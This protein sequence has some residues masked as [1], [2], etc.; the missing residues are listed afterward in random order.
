MSVTDKG[1]VQLFRE[2]NIPHLLDTQGYVLLTADEIK[3]ISGREPRLMV[4]F[5]TREYRPDT[6]KKADCTI[7]PVRNG[8]YVIVRGDGYVRLP[9]VLTVRT[10]DSDPFERLQTLPRLCKSESQ[11]IDV[12][13]ASGMLERFV[14]EAG[15][16]LTIRGR[17]R[18]CPFG[19]TFHGASALKFQVNGVQV[20]VDAGYEGDR[21][22]LVEAKMGARDDFIVRQLYYPYRMWLESGISKPLVC[23]FLT[24][25][26]QVFSISEY[27]FDS[28]E[29]YNSITHVRTENFTLDR[30]PG[31]PDLSALLA[32]TRP[33]REP[34]DIPFPQAND[35]RKVIDVI[36]GVGNGIHTKS[37]ITEYYEFAD[38]QS[39]YYGDAARYLGFLDGWRGGYVL[40]D[41]GREFVNQTAGQRVAMMATAMLKRPV[42]RLVAEEMLVK[43]N[44]PELDQIAD[45]IRI[46]RPDLHGTT[47]R[48][49]AS[50]L[51]RWMDWL[52]RSLLQRDMFCDQ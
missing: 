24:Y 37:R 29:V 19:F 43:G 10:F 46:E 14:D 27:R 9:D 6:L 33:A 25:S 3:S 26:N 30:S 20:E 21:I 4:K 52:G 11:V 18:S 12:A 15:L 16:M 32:A 17:L 34:L 31:P 35:M 51:T 36:D 48:R 23:L 2:L 47:L 45:A 41:A 7:L 28:P 1:W 38:R 22:Y 8:Q 39:N 44:A 13:A 42:I 50:G 40:T 49:R 5:D